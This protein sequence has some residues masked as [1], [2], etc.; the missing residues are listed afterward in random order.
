MT[1][2]SVIFSFGR[3]R[4]SSGWLRGRRRGARGAAQAAASA[5]EARKLRRNMKIGDSILN[6]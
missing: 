4:A 2:T 5:A 3:L 1:L 6:P